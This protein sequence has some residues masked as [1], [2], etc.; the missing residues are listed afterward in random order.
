MQEG[1]VVGGRYAIEEVLGRGGM[2]SVYRAHDR[3]LERDV[4]LKILNQALSGDPEHVERFRREARAIAQLS[5][6]NRVTVIDRGQVEGHEFIVFELVRG[7]NLKEL[8]A[9]QRAL[10]VEEALGYLESVPA[11]VPATV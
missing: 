7:Q 5:H 8:L 10:P 3:V 4:A 9:E 11:A 1:D 2:S 6:P